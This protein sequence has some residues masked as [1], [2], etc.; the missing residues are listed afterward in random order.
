MIKFRVPEVRA[1]EIERL[2]PIGQKIPGITRQVLV[3]QFLGHDPLRRIEHRHAIL[4][5]ADAFDRCQVIAEVGL[6]QIVQGIDAF[7][8]QDDVHAIQR[9]HFLG[10]RAGM[11]ADEAG[12]V[13]GVLLFELPTEGGG[14][15]HVGGA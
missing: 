9:E 10:Q 11:R 5:V 4:L 8:E 2:F 3:H 1:V 6:E 14:A 15:D 7:V 12:G 13:F